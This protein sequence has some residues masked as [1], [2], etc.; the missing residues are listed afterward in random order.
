MK[1]CLVFALGSRARCAFFVAFAALTSGCA[2]QNLADNPVNRAAGV[3]AS[4]LG[5]VN[6]SVASGFDSVD[7]SLMNVKYT[8]AGMPNEYL[9][10]ASLGTRRETGAGP[11]PDKTYRPALATKATELCKGQFLV[12]NEHNSQASISLQRKLLAGRIEREALTKTGAGLNRSPTIDPYEQRLLNTYPE[13]GLAWHIRCGE[14]QG[15]TPPPAPRFNVES[16]PKQ[17]RQ[18]INNA[19]Q[20]AERLTANVPR[21]PQS[22]YPKALLLV[23]TEIA[24]KDII[25]RSGASNTQTKVVQGSISMDNLARII[26]RRH[27][28]DDVDIQEATALPGPIAGQVAFYFEGDDMNISVPGEAPRVVRL[29]AAGYVKYIGP[30]PTSRFRQ[31]DGVELVVRL[32]EDAALRAA[33]P[34]KG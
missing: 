3:I 29:N 11:N 22:L 24:M 1:N 2:T 32:A 16:V 13:A 34:G 31:E 8:P 9:L 33:Q 27:I 5:G 14:G 25:L 23:P 18:F 10:S 7:R 28:F 20:N 19:M 15:W 12:L 26:Q 30:L 17:D 4:A 21:L 6:Q